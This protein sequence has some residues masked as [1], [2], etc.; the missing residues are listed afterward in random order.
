MVEECIK[1]AV[2][3]ILARDYPWLTAPAGVRATVT[4]V[5]PAAGAEGWYEHTLTVTNRFGA[6][7]AA[8]PPLPGVLSR[9]QYAAGT[10]VYAALIRGG[11]PV[12][13]GEAAP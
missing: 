7:D 12:I 1:A 4:E 11:E 3:K 10:A 6:T 9:T 2:D 13:L 5:R 8:F